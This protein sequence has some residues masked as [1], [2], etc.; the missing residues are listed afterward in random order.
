M[1]KQ[2]SNKERER[3]ASRG[4]KRYMER[5]VETEEADKQ[6]K[7]FD[8]EELIEDSKYERPVGGVDGRRR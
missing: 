6:I 8:R 2:K 3:E 5:L 1:L 4:K 7:E